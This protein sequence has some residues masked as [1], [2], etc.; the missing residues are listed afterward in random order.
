MAGTG[1]LMI[2]VD[3]G[4]VEKAITVA[5]AVA[6]VTGVAVLLFT[7]GDVMLGMAGVGVRQ[8]T[9][10]ANRRNRSSLSNPFTLTIIGRISPLQNWGR[11]QSRG[12]LASSLRTSRTHLL[13]Q[14]PLEVRI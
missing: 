11:E 8:A 10:V 7:V 1:L 13:L 4:L 6:I 12:T 9:V 14:T 3:I 5:T 2:V